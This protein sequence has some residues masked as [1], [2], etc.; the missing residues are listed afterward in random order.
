MKTPGQRKGG[1]PGAG[2]KQATPHPTPPRPITT[3]SYC[4][5][6]NRLGRPRGLRGTGRSSTHGTCRRLPPDEVAE[7]EARLRREGRL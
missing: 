5:I 1:G 6:G 7:I 3:S 2:K 4:P